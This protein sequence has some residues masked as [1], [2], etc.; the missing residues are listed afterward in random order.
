METID[1]LKKQ[2]ELL[3]ETISNKKKQAAETIE[4]IATH[5]YLEYINTHLYLDEEY[6][7]RLEFVVKNIAEDMAEQ[8]KKQAEL[9]EKNPAIQ[10]LRKKIIDEKS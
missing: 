7:K 1:N 2:K 9:D 10:E 6:A 8:I 5:T 4:K 3:E